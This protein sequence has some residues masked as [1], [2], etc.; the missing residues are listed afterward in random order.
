MF[1]N[2]LPLALLI[3]VLAGPLPHV[4]AQITDTVNAEVNQEASQHWRDFI[5]Y[6]RIGRID[7]AAAHGQSLVQMDLP[8]EEMLAVVENSPYAD[9]WRR[10][11]SMLQRMEDEAAQQANIA[12]IAE[13]VEDTVEAAI[14]EVIRDPKRI[15]EQIDLLNE[16][17]RPQANATRRLREAGQYAVPQLV[18]VLLTETEFDEE[19]RPYVIEAMA[20]MGRD[21]VVPLAESMKGLTPSAR[22]DA[23]RILGRIGYAASLP[24]MK[25]LIEA[26]DTQEATQQILRQSFTQIAGRRGVSLQTSAAELYLLLAEDYYQGRESLILEPD[27]DRNLQWTLNEQ[28]NLQPLRVPTEIYQYTMAMRMARNALQ[29]DADLS[30]ALSLW[31]AANFQ[32]QNHLPEGA[33]DPTYGPDMQSPAFYARLAGIGHTR[34]VL[35]RALNDRDA[36]LALDAIDAMAATAGSESL[37]ADPGPLVRALHYPDRR[38]RFESAFAI[39]RA[40]PQQGFIGSGRVVPVLAEAVRQTSTPTAIVLAPD[41]ESLN[42]L[43][44]AVRE[45]GNY[46]VVIGLSLTDIATSLQTLPGADLI[47][48]EGD[49]NYVAQFDA[50]RQ[51]EYKV[52]I[53]P[54]VVLARPGALSGLR[55]RYELQP[56]AVVT[57]ADIEAEQL[58]AAMQEALSAMRKGEITDAQAEAYAVDS[59]DLLYDLS[60]CEHPVFTVAG[61]MPSLT[62]ALEDGRAAVAEGAG[63]VL[64]TLDQETAQQALADAALDGVRS[65]SLRVAWLNDLAMNARQ[66]GRMITQRQERQLIELVADSQGELA[67]AAA[68]AHGALDLPTANS[69]QLITE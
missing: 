50:A 49:L 4:S 24:F 6:G 29:L 32:R 39:A 23:A 68:K 58:Q 66:F 16:G 28:L 52:Q 69:V 1:K 27:A 37:L 22:Q 56:D 21:I 15:R 54:M 20:Q 18:R 45:A 59:L 46:D 40:D 10:T 57:R 35:T 12:E 42:E 3:G 67:D 19:H 51:G 55:S 63:T 44:A 53:A 8:A 60:M 14:L 31:I 43:S 47:V 64:A 5:H 41:Q 11:A 2:A 25:E 62:E 65:T 36:E 34:P 7:L 9:N 17:L 26:E 33:D 30:P 61:A 38:V 48:V 13:Q